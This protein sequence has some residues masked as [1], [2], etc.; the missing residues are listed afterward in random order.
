MR[1]HLPIFGLKFFLP[2][3]LLLLGLGTDA[4]NQ[5]MYPKRKTCSFL[6]GFPLLTQSYILER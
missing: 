2:V 1:C 5:G 6:C 3:C 4:K